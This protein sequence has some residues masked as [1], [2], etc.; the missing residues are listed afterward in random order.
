MSGDR[1]AAVPLRLVD[2]A[3]DDSAVSGPGG[4]AP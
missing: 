4:R 3:G 2:G 1:A